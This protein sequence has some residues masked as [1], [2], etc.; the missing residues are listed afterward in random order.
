MNAG[1]FTSRAFIGTVGAIIATGALLNLANKGT[2]GATAQKF[3]R[4]V[5][6][7]YGAGSL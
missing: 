4:Y 3:S 6:T 5:T 2:F 1:L 7:G